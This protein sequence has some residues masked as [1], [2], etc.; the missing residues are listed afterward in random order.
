MKETNTGRFG[1][2]C[3]AVMSVT[4]TLNIPNRTLQKSV[5]ESPVCVNVR[6]TGTSFRYNPCRRLQKKRKGNDCTTA[7][8]GSTSTARVAWFCVV[9][10]FVHL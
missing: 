1:E 4:L 2:K 5:G 7:T 9:S 8:A 10:H 6:L 3:V